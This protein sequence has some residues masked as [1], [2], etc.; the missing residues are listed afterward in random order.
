MVEDALKAVEIEVLSNTL[1]SGAT[2][3][4][5]YVEGKIDD[6]DNKFS[7]SKENEIVYT[8]KNGTT[9]TVTINLNNYTV[10]NVK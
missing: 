10:T 1:P 6:T 4:T 8:P 7:T 2:A 9:Y 5:A 3:N